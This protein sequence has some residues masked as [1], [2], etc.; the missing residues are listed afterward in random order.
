MFNDFFKK[1][2]NKK[3]L[4]L[5]DGSIP[6]V[7]DIHAEFDAAQ[8]LFL[9]S[10]DNLLKEL[11]IP[12][13]SHIEKKADMLKALGFIN[14]ET[15]KKAEEIKRST[16]GIRRTYEMTEKKANLIKYYKRAY[17][18]EKF[19]P[20]EELNRICRKY[21]LIHAPAKNYIKDI[22]E[23]NVLEMA[24][25]KPLSYSDSI[26]ERRYLTITRFYADV[27]EDIKTILKGEV[28]IPTDLIDLFRSS[29]VSEM[30]C[31]KLLKYL[32]YTGSYSGYIFY[33]ASMKKVD[34]RGL[35]VAAPNSHFDLAGVEKT[36]EFG[37]GYQ[38]V[39]I[40]EIKDPVVFEYCKGD[41]CRIITKWGTD[42]DQSYLDPVLTNEIQ[43]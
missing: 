25:R 28:K 37:Y 36:S 38:T 12:T 29:M 17:P 2:L 3:P 39:E 33:D 6:T 4:V 5:S 13:E 40:M 14:S 8:D 9:E 24:N 35:R 11:N 42:D 32:G 7:E 23:K 1:S 10:A 30:S 43:N 19:I 27:P 34:E 26:E 31:T 15:I 41:I 22:P 20:V 21:N 16:N 18:L